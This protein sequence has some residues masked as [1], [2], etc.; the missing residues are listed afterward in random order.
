MKET[1]E[2]TQKGKDIPCSWIGKSVLLKCL[3][4]PKQ[5]AN[6]MQSLSKHHEILHK[7]V[8]N[9]PKIYMESP[10]GHPKQKEQNWKN[11]II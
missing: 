5:S 7:N 1:E 11:H 3:Y 9:N 10:C 4:H 2:D 8:R 6:L